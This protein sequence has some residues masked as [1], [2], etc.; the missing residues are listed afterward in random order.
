MLRHVVAALDEA[1]GGAQVLAGHPVAVVQDELHAGKESGDDSSSS[2]SSP[3]F[4]T[5][6]RALNNSDEN[7]D[8]SRWKTPRRARTSS[9]DWRVAAPEKV[10]DLRSR[11]GDR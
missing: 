8:S 4:R 6:G 10:S 9:P 1:T 2:A 11:V 5:G 7:A 3:V